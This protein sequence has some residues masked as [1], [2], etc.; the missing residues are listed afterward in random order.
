MR[1]RLFF[2][3]RDLR[4]LIL[5]PSPLK[6]FRKSM[7]PGAVFL[8]KNLLLYNAGAFMQALSTVDISFKIVPN[9]Q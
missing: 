7:I 3:S 4:N 2:I 8:R 6:L 5:Q 9:K 1:V